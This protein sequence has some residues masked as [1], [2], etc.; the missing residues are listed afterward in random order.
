[1]ATTDKTFELP[2]RADAPGGLSYPA[3][4]EPPRTERRRL[5][6]RTCCLAVVLTVL[7]VGLFVVACVVV[8]NSGAGGGVELFALSAITL[9]PGCYASYVLV[10]TRLQWEGFDN[11][12]IFNEDLE[13]V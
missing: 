9:L 12:V 7:G 8:A 10:G 5:P 2:K 3:G 1:M 13:L 6:P 11:I 4:M